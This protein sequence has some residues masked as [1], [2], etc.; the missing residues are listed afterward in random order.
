MPPM[1][2][3]VLVLEMCYLNM[4]DGWGSS[5]FQT[6]T[7]HVLFSLVFWKY[8]QIAE[9]AFLVWNEIPSFSQLVGSAQQQVCEE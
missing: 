8:F 6:M 5:S 4:S 7:V 1:A 9:F 2:L 3:T